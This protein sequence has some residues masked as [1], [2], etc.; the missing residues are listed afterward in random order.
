MR[1]T[2]RMEDCTRDAKAFSGRGT[3]TY[4]TACT[5]WSAP[6]GKPGS[7]LTLKQFCLNSRLENRELAEKGESEIVSLIGE[8]LVNCLEGFLL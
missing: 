7:R 2:S 5:C 8:R 6:N 1:D 4:S 3:V